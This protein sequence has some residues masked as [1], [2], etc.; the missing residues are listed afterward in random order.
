MKKLPRL[1]IDSQGV[2]KYV[3]GTKYP[4]SVSLGRLA[5][6]C[7]DCSHITFLPD[8]EVEDSRNGE[9]KIFVPPK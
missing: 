8:M 6:P 3:T 5:A 7:D 1:A 4:K 9:F 2:L